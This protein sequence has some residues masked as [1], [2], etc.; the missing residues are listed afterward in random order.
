MHKMTRNKELVILLVTAV[1]GLPAAQETGLLKVL[2]LE[3]EGAFNDIQRK[4]ARDPVVEVRD[5]NDHPVAGA[6]VVFTL[7]EGGASG[8]F[9]GGSRTFLAATD[10]QGRA[11]A[12]G[13]KP[14]STEGRFNIRV[15]ASADGKTGRTMISQS[16]TLAGGV[17]NPGRGGG[18]KKL[19]LLLVAGGAAG[20]I[21]AGRRGGS[22]AP[23]GSPPI[24]LSSGSVS[25]GVPR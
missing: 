4:V 8:N 11:A 25:V 22:P 19:V 10:A 2:V 5:E 7:P 1:C 13:L 3:G 9:A 17:I 24:V 12:R 23:A 16:N 14:N 15:I 18:K 21:F 6:Q 20:G